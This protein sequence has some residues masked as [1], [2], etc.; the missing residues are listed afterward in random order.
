MRVRLKRWLFL[1]HRWLGVV[2]CAFF[3]MWFVSGVVMMY[4]GYPKLTAAER[5]QHLPPL[6]DGAGLLSPHSALQAAGVDGPLKELR[7]AAAR[8]GRPVYLAVQQAAAPEAGQRRRAAPGGGTVVIDA[9]SGRRLQG[10]DTE[11]AL[12][13]AA[14]FAGPTSPQAAVHDLGTVQEDAFT[15]SRGLD[16]HRPLHRIAVADTHGTWLYVSSLTGEVV[17][18]ATRSERLWNYAGAWI[19]WLYPFRGNVFDRWWTDIVNWLSIAG[20]AAAVAG[21]VVGVMRWRFRRPYRSGARSPYPGRMMRWHHVSGLVFAGFT[22]TW[23]FSGLMSMNPWRIF[24]T[25]AAP[26]RAD[27]LQGAPL[28]PG[29]QDAAPAVL[30]AAAGTGTRELRWTPVLGTL[31][32]QA[33]SPGGRPRLLRSTDAQPHAV[34]EGQLRSFAAGLLAAPVARID[35]LSAYD[36]HYYDRA[37]HTMTGGNDM[38]L[39]VLRVVFSD[40]QASWV[41]IDPATG[42]VL[43]RIDAGR[44]ASR[45]LFAM[46]HSWDWLPLLERRPMWDAVLV[47]LSLGGTALSLTGVVIGWRRLV[48]KWR[49]AREHWKPARS[50]AKQDTLGLKTPSQ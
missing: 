8:G 1:V 19:H 35:H 5:L 30:L 37:E 31:V 12:A 32:V 33:W 10:V 26:L 3:A 24:D 47:L 49:G 9:A 7:L 2:L 23:I 27:A 40:P 36:F 22:I 50:M 44:R 41:H 11:V 21:T 16:A 15:H 14:A 13:S 6:G 34:D 4:V 17:R 25:G 39:P 42:T 43:G 18:D 29:P 38:P 46:L 48:L 28:R 20:I 45:W